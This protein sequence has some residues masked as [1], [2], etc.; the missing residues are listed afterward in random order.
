MLLSL[1][2]VESKHYN[3]VDM[4]LELGS[5]RWTVPSQCEDLLGL[6]TH[7]SSIKL[8][9][10]QFLRPQALWNYKVTVFILVPQLL[11]ILAFIGECELVSIG[12]RVVLWIFT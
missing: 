12:P 3:K 8:K 11:Y 1:P 10:S 9:A 5:K 7:D 4:G 2:H 6:W